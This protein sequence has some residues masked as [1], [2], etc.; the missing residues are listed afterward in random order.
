MAIKN[1]ENVNIQPRPFLKWAGGKGQLLPILKNNIP[2]NFNTYFEPF[3]GGGALFFSLLPPK[4][5]INDLN[6]EIF[7]LYSVLKNHTD[8][9]E[10]T[11]LQFENKSD[12]YS[13]LRGID[14]IAP[15]YNEL[16]NVT[17]AART[18]YLNKTCYNGLFRVNK[19][20]QFNVPFGNYKNPMFFDRDNFNLLRGYLNKA[21]IQ[22]LNMDFA[23][24]VSD[25]KKGDFVYFDPP[26]DPVTITSSFTDYN[27]D[28]FG[29][30]DQV[31]LKK[32]CDALN[33]RGVLFLLSNSSTPF[34]KELYSNYKEIGVKAKRNINSNGSKRGEV[35]EILVR[36]Y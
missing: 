14:K 33:E 13:I 20:G 5:V 19:A 24:A 30:T 22:I 1:S 7:N 28:G 21:S 12:Y 29:K 26:Y 25:A 2:S 18:L 8:E 32:L 36:N 35:S 34:I 23:D 27:K 4:A 6:F 9:L 11:I 16:S 15:V 31:R 3:I 10:E 17:K